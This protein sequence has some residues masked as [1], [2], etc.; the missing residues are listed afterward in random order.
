MPT[1]LDSTPFLDDPTELRARMR[2]DGYLLIR[3]LLPTA[4]LEALRL[5]FL[6]VAR[7]ECLRGQP[8]GSHAQENE[9]PVEKGEDKRAA[10]HGSE[11][12]R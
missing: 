10:R 5:D 12:D 2:R 7:T 8:S 4:N 9:G 3:D 11:I 6:A 1:F